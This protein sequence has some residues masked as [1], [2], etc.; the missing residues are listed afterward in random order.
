MKE[1]KG[2]N[3]FAVTILELWTLAK[4]GTNGTN[5]I[6]NG[7]TVNQGNDYI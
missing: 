1:I 6:G 7:T 5:E 2:I 3:H 4:L